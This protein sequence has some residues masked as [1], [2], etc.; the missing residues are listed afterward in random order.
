MVLMW[1][2]E[3]RRKKQEQLAREQAARSALYRND[4]TEAVK[5]VTA[6]QEFIQL[7]NVFWD[8]E[9]QQGKCLIFFK[10]MASRGIPREITRSLAEKLGDDYSLVIHV[11]AEGDS[12]ATQLRAE[13]SPG[14]R[15][16]ADES[17]RFSRTFES[18]SDL[19]EWLES[20]EGR[21]S[22]KHTYRLSISSSIEVPV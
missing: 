21:W 6:S 13:L 19:N 5:E 9:G 7:H 3:N 18:V 1:G 22:R 8:I 4:I 20:Y 16:H 2:S 17:V 12:L 14:W 11:R 10:E 15:T